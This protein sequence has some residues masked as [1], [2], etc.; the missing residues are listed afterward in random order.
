MGIAETPPA[1]MPTA[2]EGDVCRQAGSPCTLMGKETVPLCSH[3]VTA[4]LFLKEVKHPK[5][6]TQKVAPE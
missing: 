4:T 2:V 3:C 5:G 1:C 6:E